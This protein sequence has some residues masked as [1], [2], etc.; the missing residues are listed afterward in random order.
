MDKDIL[1]YI[2]SESKQG[3]ADV[4]EKDSRFEV[5]EQLFLT[6]LSYQSALI[7]STGGFFA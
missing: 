1:N 2:K 7:A 5:F 6:E 3:F 4:L